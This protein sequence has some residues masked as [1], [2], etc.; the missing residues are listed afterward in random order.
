MVQIA[1]KLA[2]YG[3]Q[4]GGPCGILV[5]LVRYVRFIQDRYC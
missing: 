2:Y 3:G 5:G 1:A 4:L